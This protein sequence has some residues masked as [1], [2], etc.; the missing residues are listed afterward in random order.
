MKAPAILLAVAVSVLQSATAATDAADTVALENRVLRLVVEQAPAPFIE[1]LVHKASG[2]ALV[3]SPTSKSLFSIAL[4]N[5]DGDRVTLDSTTAGTSNVAVTKTGATSK[6][7]IAYGAFPA[8]GVSVEVAVLCDEQD[9][10]TLWTIRV[11]CP[12]GCRVKAV[13]FPQVL[14][15][16]TISEGDDDCLVLPALSGTLIENPAKNWR[17]GFGVTLGY[18]GNLSAQFLAY[19]DRSA[20]LYLAGRDTEG[21]PMSLGVSKRVEGFLCWHAYTVVPD[22]GSDR[23]GTW[24]SPYPVAVGVTQGRWYDTADRYKQW[25]VLQPWCEKTLVQRDDVPAWWKE[26]PD[27]HVC[28]VRTYD[29]ERTCSGSYYPKLR[30]Y[31][32]TLR[33]KID[34]PVVAMLAGWENHR[35]WTAG[36]YFPIFDE[37]RAQQVLRQLREDGIRPFFFLSGMFYTYWNEGRD[38]AEI[39]AA[40]QYGSS[41]V[42]DEQSG[43]PKEYVLNESSP[44]GEWRRHSYQFCP[45][46]PQTAEFF[47]NVIDQAHALGVDVLQMD[48]TVSGAGGACW[49]AGHGHAPGEGVYQSLAFWDLLDTMRR[50]GKGLS[51]DFVLFHEEPHEQ[52]IQHLD[53]FHVRE[54]YE[55]RWYRGYPGAVGIPLF[56][57]LYHEFA[58]GYGGDSAGLSA[59]DSRWNVRCH[60]MN[61]A[62]GR[63]PGGAVWSAP[64]NML[65]AHPDQIAMI[66]S[67]CRLLKTRAK[68]FL[69]LG[70]MLHP[71]ELTVPQVEVAISVRR[72]DQWVSESMPTPA[73]LTSSW[74]SPDERIGHLF[75]NVAETP[76]PLSVDLD[77]RNAPAGASYDGQVW[78]STDDGGFRPLWHG[79]RLPMDFSTEL[80]P[81]EVVFVAVTLQP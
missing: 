74:Q 30:E 9:P 71:Y 20:G 73:I 68:D 26:G 54:Y 44:S 78:R 70:T 14:A 21:R 67:H 65:D 29:R 64:Q 19:Q 18:P 50:H 5:Q 41:Y 53:G 28:E 31:L 52:L 15:V 81:G 4:T 75:V 57:Y 25:A 61:L 51:P 13:R 22:D 43:K 42:V 48:Q 79:Q 24:E 66:R 37:D 45:A 39:P 63:T 47:C 76:Q 56:S 6:A 23:D 32:H 10:L 3:A 60:A 62:A 8:P 11:K 77:T 16:P 2:Q 34:G 1:R 12:A 17:D 55:K 35:R 72:G 69:M 59:G 58:V 33:D 27:V 38:A 7:V 40:E 46:A 80:K 49:S 36:A